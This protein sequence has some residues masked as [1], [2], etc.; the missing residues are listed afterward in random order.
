MEDKN[1]CRLIMMAFME[2][3]IRNE[4]WVELGILG[5]VVEF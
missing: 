1:D 5:A 3:V 2:G 4:A